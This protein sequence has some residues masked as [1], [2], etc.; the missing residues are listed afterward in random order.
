MQPGRPRFI[1]AD[2]RATLITLFIQR[3]TYVWTQ[4]AKLAASKGYGCGGTGDDAPPYQ[5]LNRKT[6]DGQRNACV[7]LA[8]C[9]QVNIRV[10]GTVPPRLPAPSLCECTHVYI[11]IYI[12][13]NARICVCTSLSCTL[14][15]VSI[16]LVVVSLN[17]AWQ[18]NNAGKILAKR[19]TAGTLTATMRP[20]SQPQ[21]LLLPPPLPYRLLRALVGAKPTTRP[22]KQSV[23]T[24]RVKTVLGAGMFERPTC[25]PARLL[26]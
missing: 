5:S 22:G 18:Y 7:T 23:H 24:R 25:M 17:V 16:I 1:H 12:Y 15:W 6:S 11:Y 13:S 2:V 20:K 3:P 26:A 21:L 8:T 19:S 4:C 10:C 14:T 9:W